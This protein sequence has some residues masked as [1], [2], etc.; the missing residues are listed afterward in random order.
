MQTMKW[1]THALTIFVLAING[2]CASKEMD[3]IE[4]LDISRVNFDTT[5]IVKVECNEF[6]DIFKE[7]IERF[8]IHNR[9]DIQ[10]FSEI[11][12]GLT[13]SGGNGPDV[14]ARV[15]VHYRN[16]DADTLCVAHTGISL[17]GR[18][19]TPSNK[20]VIFIQNARGSSS[21]GKQNR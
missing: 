21:P 15:L 9:S 16:G 1:F 18:P 12:N 5:T 14:R 11:L 19:M 6:M 7:D 8:P 2:A 4:W 3:S 13:P 17:N 20:M 10:K